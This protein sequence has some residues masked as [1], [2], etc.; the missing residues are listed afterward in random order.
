MTIQAGRALRH[1]ITSGR[2]LE[3]VVHFGVQQVFGRQAANYTCLLVL[4]RRGS[5]R[6]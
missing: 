1:L 5:A 4:D 3:K 2:S 6:G